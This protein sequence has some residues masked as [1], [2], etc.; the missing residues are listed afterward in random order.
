MVCDLSK[1]NLKENLENYVNLLIEGQLL[2]E[3]KFNYKDIISTIQK[4]VAGAKNDIQQSLGIAYHVPQ[5]IFDTIRNNPEFNENE[6]VERGYDS[7]QLI[8]DINTLK[9]AEDKMAAIA[10]LLGIENTSIEEIEK[11]IAQQATNPDKI[12][13][14]V[15]GSEELAIDNIL[16]VD[17][18]NL[19]AQQ[20]AEEK[21]I[22]GKT[23]SSRTARDADKAFYQ[24]GLAKILLARTSADQDF[25]ELE[26]D[27]HKGFR[28]KILYEKNI[29]GKKR[30]GREDWLPRNVVMLVL[31]DN[32][33]NIMY[34]DENHKIANVNTGKPIYFA[35]KTV[36]VTNT[37]NIKASLASKFKNIT[38]EQ[39]QEI[40]EKVKKDAEALNKLKKKLE[41]TESVLVNLTGGSVG[42]AQKLDIL[43]EKEQKEGGATLSEFNQDSF[44]PNIVFV[45]EVLKGV[46]RTLPAVKFY[47]AENLI[48]LKN[49]TTLGNQDPELM[50]HLITV[51]T[52]D[53]GLTDVEKEQYVSQFINLYRDAAESDAKLLPYV[54]GIKTDNNKK[55][56]IN[57]N[58]V[59]VPLENKEVSKQMLKDFF[60]NSV[61]I[62]FNNKLYTKQQY[63][64]YTIEDTAIGYKIVSKNE[65]AYKPFIFS[66]FT[67]RV[68]RDKNTGLPMVVNGYLNFESELTQA[69]VK[70]QVVETR[71]NTV[72]QNIPITNTEAEEDLDDLKSSK[73]IQNSATAE[74]DARA[75]NWWRNESALAKEVDSAGKPLFSLSLLRNVVNSDAWANFSNSTITLF[76]GASFTQVYHEAW[77][78][79]SQVY[80]TKDER[81]ELLYKPVSKLPG[82]FNVVKKFVEPGGGVSYR[83]VT[84]NFKDLDVNKKQD[85]LLIEEFIAEE[86]RKYAM[87][88]GKFKTD[89][90][91]KTALGRIFDRIWKALKALVGNSDVYSN[92]S[93]EGVLGDMFNALYS[94]KS[95]KDLLP[96]SANLK[97]AEF[98]SL[99]SGGIVTDNAENDLSVSE[100]L[101]LTRTI[102]GILSEY[103]NEQ[104]GKGHFSAVTKVFSSR[105]SLTNIYNRAKNRL[106]DKI[107]QLTDERSKLAPTDEQALTIINDKINLLT[108]AV[109]DEVFG[110]IGKALAGQTANVSVVSFHKNNST[111]KDL[112][113]TFK[114]IVDEKDSDD[115]EET[116]DTAQQELATSLDASS[117]DV[118]SEKLADDLV[119]YVIKSLNKQTK[120]GEPE[121]NE[122]GF[123]EPI[124][125]LPFWR[126]LM[127]K[128]SGETS[129]LGLYNNLKNASKVSPL[130]T[131][132]LGKIYSQQTEEGELLSPSDSL[133][134]MFKEGSDIGALW[135]KFVQSTN[136]HKVDIVSTV[137][138]EYSNKPTDIRVGKTTAD[139][140]GIVN[141]DWPLAFQQ[142]E[143]DSFTY[144]KDQ[145]N[146][147]DLEAVVNRY[148]IKG[149][150][151]ENKN[152]Y[153][154]SKENYIPFL[155]SIGLFLS[156]MSE[157]KDSL[158]PNDIDFIADAIGQT[159]DSNDLA[160]K[161]KD[162]VNID[163][164]IVYLG[165]ART[166]SNG[167]KLPANAFAVNKLAETEASYSTEY[168]NSMRFNAAKKLKSLFA[169]NSTDTQ[170]INGLKKANKQGDLYSDNPE[171]VHMNF[172]NPRSNPLTK[173]SIILKSL[174]SSVTGIKIKDNDINYRDLSGISY[175]D[176]TYAS[177]GVTSAKMG[178]L[179]KVLSVFISTLGGGYMDGIQAGDK[180]SN[181]GV[182]L[183]VIDTYDEKINKGLYVDTVAFMKDASGR[184]IM[185]YN[186][187]QKILD[188][189]YPKL[190]G[191]IRRIAMVKA[192][193]E[194]Y[195]NITG[196]ERGTEFDIFDEILDGS[197]GL[198]EALK[199]EELFESL[200][201]VGDLYIVLNDNPALK[202]QLNDNIIK[203]FDK[204]EESYNKDLF[205]PIFG[206]D[207]PLP[208]ILK[209][210]I[211]K[212]LVNNTKEKNNIYGA[213]PED[214]D[215]NI[216]KA[217]IKSYMFNNFIHKTETTLLLQGDGFQF[218]H[219]KDDM[220]KRGPGSQSGGT[221]FPVDLLTKIFIDAKVGRPYEQKLI[222]DKIIA[223]KEVRTYGPTLNS[224]I[225]Q[226]SEVTSV[227]FNMYRD[228]FKR[229]YIDKGLTDE[230][231]INAALY[232]VDPDTGEIGN[233]EVDAE[234]NYSNVFKGGKMKAF[235][236]IQDADGQA[237][238]TF[239]TYRILRQAEG[240]WS[241]EQEALYFKV[242]NGETITATELTNMFPVYKLQYDGPLATEVGR[243]PIQAFHKYSLFPLIPS[244]IKDFPANDVHKAMI[245]QN[246]DY[247]TFTSGSKRS[248]IKSSPESKGDSIYEGDTSNLKADFTF[249]PNTIYIAYL[250]NQTSVNTYFKQQSTFST[251]LRKLITSLLYAYGVPTDY[252]KANNFN[253]PEEAQTAW[254]KVK[255]KRL[256]SK[257]HDYSEEFKE[258][259][260]DYVKFKKEELLEE[261]G[262]TE[263]DLYA[264]KVDDAKIKSMLVVL[265]KEFKRQGF[266]AHER[267]LLESSSNIDKLDLSVSPLA[268][269]FERMIMAMVNN[270]LVKTKLKGEPL[271]E[272]S[273]A[274]MQN[275]KLRNATAE[276]KAKYKDDFATNGLKPYAVDGIN[277]S[278]GFMFKRALGK[279]DENLFQTDYFILN[280][281]GE[282]VNSGQPIA[283]YKDEDQEE[284]DFDASFIRLNEMLRVDAW[285]ANDENNK[286]LRLTGVRI[287]VQGHNSMEF[288]EVAEFLRPEA[289]PI[290]IIPAEIV[291]KSG[292]DF[293]VDKMTTYMPFLTRS[294]KL[295]R[296]YDKEGI[297]AE[298]KELEQ[299]F[300]DLKIT[301]GAIEIL[302]NKKQAQ[303]LDINL[304][305]NDFRK[306]VS[307]RARGLNID[308][309]LLNSLTSS[310][311]KEIIKIM[312]DPNVEN[313]VKE[314]FPKASL[315]YNY[316]IKGITLEDI[317]A[318]DGALRSLYKNKSELSK[319]YTELSD[320]NDNENNLGGGLQN[321]LIQDMV[322]IL[323][324]PELAA[325]LMSPNDT[326]LV[327]PYADKIKGYIQEA[328]NE[329]DFTKSLMTGNKMYKKG[330][331][332]TKI[333]T[334]T[335]NIKKH[336]EN[337]S[338]KD[339][340][341]IAAVD[342]YINNLLNMAGAKM[343]KSV[344][345]TAKVAETKRSFN[346]KTNKWDTKTVWS[347][348][349]V[350]IP[351]DLNLAHNK[352]DGAISLSHIM[353]KEGKNSIADIINQMMNGFVDAGKDAWV[354]YLQGNPEVVPKFLFLLEAGVPIET[355]AYFVSNPMTRQYVK[356]KAKAKA[357]LSKL[358]NF[359]TQYDV[360]PNM[361]KT[362]SEYLPE[363]EAE[364]LSKNDYK[365]LP[366]DSIY[367]ITTALNYFKKPETFTKETLE[368]LVK[369]KLNYKDPNQ[370]AAFLEYLYVE[371]IIEDY[372][373][374]KKAMNPDTKPSGDQYSAQA[375]IEEVA[376]L[377]NTPTL[378][379]G[380]IQKLSTDSIISPYFIQDFARRL[381]SRL[382]KLRDDAQLNNF[383]IKTF[384]NRTAMSQA[385]K[386][387]GYDSETYIT[388]FKNFI[389]QYIFANELRVYKSG[390]T[391]Y[392]N[393]VINPKF[394]EQLNQDFDAGL[395]LATSTDENS[396]KN[397][398]LT[399]INGK[400]F[401]RLVKMGKDQQ[402]YF[403]PN[404]KLR[405][406]FIEF[407][408]EREY[409]RKR[410]TLADVIDT[411]EFLT[412]RKRLKD[413]G[414]LEY[415]QTDEETNEE[416]V[417]RLN[418]LTYEDM[419]ANKALTNTYNIWQLFRS[420]DNTIA[421]ELMDIITN[422]P[423]MSDL[424]KYS[425][426]KQFMP[427]GIPNIA[428]YRDVLNFQL[429]NYENLDE[430]LIS[431]YYTQWN[432]LSNVGEP[433]LT[434]K[435]YSDGKANAYISK[436]F[437]NLPIY[438]F[439][440][441]GMDSSKFSLSSMMPY[442]KYQEIMEKA[443]EKFLKKIETT[444][445]DTIF[446]GLKKLFEMENSASQGKLRNRGA[447]LK[448]DISNLP[449]A[450]NNIYEQP[451]IKPVTGDTE[452]PTGIFNITSTYVQNG[453]EYPV[454]KDRVEKLIKANPNVIFLLSPADLH[455][456]TN[457][458][459]P[460]EIKAAQQNIDIAIDR[461]LSQGNDVVIFAEGFGNSP[462]NFYS[463]NINMSSTPISKGIVTEKI[464]DMPIEVG[465]F[466][467]NNNITYIVT[468][469]NN[470]GTWQVYNPNAEG[471]NSKKSFS[472][473]NLIAGIN[474]A[475]KVTY[476]D[477]DYLVTPKDTIISLKSNTKMKW[478]DNN[479]DRKAILKLKD[480]KSITT[481]QSADEKEVDRLR[482][483]E[484]AEY[485]ALANPSDQE[486]RKEIYLK[487]D[488]LL[489]PLMKKIDATQPST[490]VK[491][492]GKKNLFTV[493]PIRQPDMLKAPA[494]ASVSTK[495]IGYGEGSTGRYRN[496]I[497]T[498]YANIGTY[499]KDDIVFVSING[500]GKLT[501]NN[502]KAT[503]SEVKK[504][505]NAG[506]T[507]LTDNA[508]YVES[509]DYNIGEK[510]LS[511]YLKT[512]ANYSEQT[513]DGQVI[514]VWDSKTTQPSTEVLDFK[515]IP[516]FT[517]DRKREILTNLASKHKVTEKE[518][519]AYIN[520][521]LNDKTKNPVTIIN[522]LKE[523]Y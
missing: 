457:E 169:L 289:G 159:Q 387:T 233:A 120:D 261:L 243:F 132:L 147:I 113:S 348:Q 217:A 305:L 94:A 281:A 362:I 188:M 4:K 442:E 341:G 369:S 210:L 449:D 389:S 388:K 170:K 421:R 433:K 76:K 500:R 253:S 156:D 29:Q 376:G 355:I 177:D 309:D 488:K 519:Y 114:P 459:T 425:M 78:A 443:S 140:L 303:W 313:L 81:T 298:R 331:S 461:I 56:Y 323:E 171:L 352:L 342:N 242:I 186:P 178:F 386:A 373:A 312:S 209:E 90:K 358:F 520:E 21:K 236:N 450:E 380:P 163:N 98:G 330:I 84:L 194:Y 22:N 274:F 391:E 456:S 49:S 80:L 466:V 20:T 377:A 282:Y 174:F 263:D 440:Q 17:G 404:E 396:Y 288:G 267:E 245:S 23:I 479:G 349:V 86:F 46:T 175:I 497:G 205:D 109:R 419:L 385:K 101:L 473:A 250:K 180:S 216:K 471:V 325:S 363:A 273:S 167:T 306:A 145:L 493:K 202:K 418:N 333:Y 52:E 366:K 183:N 280:E 122:L 403:V 124:E 155:N 30:A 185:G 270:R 315:I 197:P 477:T 118:A 137:V 511:E 402:M 506:A 68:V 482:A 504:A 154:V 14:K 436:F 480:S 192:D 85:R 258:S 149:V 412:R 435:K 117:N 157:I 345:V 108:R 204:L 25:T 235:I 222:A 223:E 91:A 112:L 99:N 100:A 219:T 350:E 517:L 224:A 40:N 498:Q 489:T 125:F 13:F 484:K 93:S 16:S 234:G 179:D 107:I 509:S 201:K 32:Q 293:D 310:K 485:A 104:V 347:N 97:N 42:V 375:K 399:P 74:Q 254:D 133:T 226:E 277:N 417:N 478:A 393:E 33:G 426:L 371:K 340:L 491:N 336:Q 407:G 346:K 447:N 383:L 521:A 9:K 416:Y 327:K 184:S 437:E 251:Q 357:T 513:V 434:S 48:T 260:D 8:K 65:L 182:K 75:E 15:E 286:K 162:K 465:R 332:T 464:T 301:K 292:T 116:S 398:G 406:D 164:I 230:D 225:I 318:V 129:P 211:L 365:D 463:N 207:Q 264:E 462:K 191:E 429:K 244:V 384:K 452:I 284:L 512:V 448:V 372:D 468:Q 231:E 39:E 400:A 324:L 490:S 51:L 354:A 455:K 475:I 34:F 266:S 38:P 401:P 508:T 308:A 321:K 368:G 37:K 469:K 227:Y 322:N 181:F 492:F 311:S 176:E 256:E 69:E 218:D 166:L 257:F 259:I 510:K 199:S 370:I 200:N 229:D 131:Q 89:S 203:F 138:Q 126:V 246:I 337:F 361:L 420:G 237:L 446:G 115:Y 7:T 328:D 405:T 248:S 79:F 268:A 143:I 427:Q 57:L 269:R 71:N 41:D 172:L 208:A 317:D 507:I 428:A 134:K 61:Y 262:W 431:E 326:N 523:C 11:V 153:S 24:D 54:I 59:S 141:T 272:V 392:K 316:S 439:L 414:S 150:N 481:Q 161:D 382:F 88:N 158:V 45:R 410:T 460:E 295:M 279:M 374:M 394:L 1:N 121:L 28:G 499:T 344:N 451:F 290:I 214:V 474:K 26:Y 476:K 63:T 215:L 31:T 453:R 390:D 329:T 5:I 249:T 502:L 95:P 397:R 411:N 72:A 148:L 228:L 87:N 152:V 128:A 123:P 58:N 241:N 296:K 505:L 408:L 454:T 302:K 381:F 77:H 483:K 339:S 487:Y 467:F 470:N 135:M 196:F 278:I 62:H 189:L 60:T 55:L 73:L 307:I 139:Y 265:N 220:T 458:L 320:L 367:N 44:D 53:I 423:E 364:I 165:K 238:I 239:D 193:P 422:Y 432:N 353:D 43:T 92:T 66:K 206:V 18:Y 2:N 515:T 297:E 285:R 27:G 19:T 378:D 119:L 445:P 232:G 291:A 430:G 6:L 472:E 343:Q 198:K 501:P 240:N 142:K 103:V 50:D 287:P 146:Y 494:K 338:S 360:A 275:T 252:I 67:P 64:K 144:K 283:I 247:I 106:N 413:S 221:I 187:M 110:D 304:K 503:V 12:Y 444:D 136:L 314:F 522:K 83:M 3:E 495:Y 105:K 47:T 271:V 438:A 70:Q 276:E 127:D 195:N 82:S 300:E 335:Y 294:G 441:S 255:Y 151:N 415:K 130:F 486:K 212:D 518:A 213:T 424:T 395:Y 160:T 36:S 102:D 359:G 334:E 496:E 299:K 409:L 516:D 319:V 356:D 168:A 10:T 111:F 96:Y 35:L 351:L 190:E 173:G 379:P 514:G